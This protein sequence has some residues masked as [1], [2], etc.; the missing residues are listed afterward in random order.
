MHITY[1]CYKLLQILLIVSHSPE[2]LKPCAR[3]ED[4]RHRSRAWAAMAWLLGCRNP[5]VVLHTLE[6]PVLLVSHQRLQV[7]RAWL[8]TSAN[9]EVV[10][11][12]DICVV[13]D[14]CFQS[15]SSATGTTHGSAGPVPSHAGLAACGC[16]AEQSPTVN[17]SRYNDMHCIL[18]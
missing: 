8:P 2:L 16:P 9:H 4:G 18:Q 13:L 14:Q 12:A 15:T 3:P 7:G 6:T 5:G 1:C 11:P 17:L 10:T